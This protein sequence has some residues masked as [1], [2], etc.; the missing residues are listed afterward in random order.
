MDRAAL[1]PSVA[2]MGNGI[3]KNKKIFQPLNESELGFRSSV[4]IGITSQGSK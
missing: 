4:S 1:E 2:S 3:V